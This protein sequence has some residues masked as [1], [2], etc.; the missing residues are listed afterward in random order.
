MQWLRN[1]ITSTH[2][3]LARIHHMT[4]TK[5]GPGITILFCASEGTE[6]EIFDRL[7][8][9][10][11]WQLFCT[12]EKMKICT[13]IAVCYYSKAYCVQFSCA[14]R[15]WPDN[16][17]KRKTSPQFRPYACFMCSQFSKWFAR[18]NPKLYKY[19]LKMKIIGMRICAKQLKFGGEEGGT[20]EGE[21]IGSL[22]RKLKGIL[23]LSEMIKTKM[24][25][26]NF[27]Y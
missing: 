25:K 14:R 27:C 11:T 6:L 21:W 22:D 9:W 2:K 7:H 8:K 24:N 1:Y 23:Y 26:D 12:K 19:V 18:V 20:M 17:K 16:G 4:S 15:D 10:L 13:A 5:K 3:S